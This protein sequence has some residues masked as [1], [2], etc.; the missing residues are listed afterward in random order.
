MY[1]HFHLDHCEDNTCGDDQTC[2]TLADMF[3][4]VCNNTDAFLVNGN[5]TLPSSAV[6]VYN[7][8]IDIDFDHMICKLRLVK[9]LCRIF[10]YAYIAFFECHR[11]S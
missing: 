7:R 6:Q 5:C 1:F 8:F 9:L 3:Q 10:L 4:C 11:Q 2:I